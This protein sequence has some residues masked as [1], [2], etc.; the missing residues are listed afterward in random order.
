M[1]FAQKALG[2]QPSPF[3]TWLITRGIKTLP[4]RLERQTKSASELANQLANHPLINSVS[5][6]FRLDHPQQEIAVKQMQSGGAII[7][8]TI[9]GSRN[10]AYNFC[11]KLNFFTMAESLG[12]VESLVCH[13]ATMTHAS[14]RP[15]IKE[16][17]GITDS[18]IRFSVGCEDLEDLSEDLNQGL[19]ML[20]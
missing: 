3:D 14:V 9:N 8:I 18:L 11:K 17:V 6:P 4:L 13:P 19:D 12:G 5:Y 20:K 15:E 2:L 1:L 7:A 16:K 10:D